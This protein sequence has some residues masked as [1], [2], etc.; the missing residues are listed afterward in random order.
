M[1][2][3]AR[4]SPARPFARWSCRNL[5]TEGSSRRPLWCAPPRS[6]SDQADGGC[7]G[8]V[9]ANLPACARWRHR[10]SASRPARLGPPS[11]RADNGAFATT[12]TGARIMAGNKTSR[13]FRKNSSRPRI[14][15]DKP[16]LAVITTVLGTTGGDRWL[17]V[18]E[19]CWA[20][21]G[22]EVNHVHATGP[23]RTEP[24]MPGPR[25]GSLPVRDSRSGPG[26]TSGMSSPR[27]CV[28]YAAPT[29]S[30]SSRK[31]AALRWRSRCRSSLA[32]RR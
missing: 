25:R 13:V 20:S 19:D 24:P 1:A 7:G 14:R 9:D 3:T 17:Y 21:L 4:D 2:G 12:A 18:L 10:S 16:V 8:G 28:R 5:L 31:A 26:Q 6:S 27:L 23:A 29:S 15:K 11:G 32:G 30:C 22:I